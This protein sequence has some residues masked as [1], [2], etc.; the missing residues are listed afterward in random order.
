MNIVDDDSTIDQPLLHPPDHTLLL[1]AVQGNAAAIVAALGAKARL[2]PI[3]SVSVLA[4][5]A[6]LKAVD[7]RTRQTAA[8]VLAFL[9]PLSHTELPASYAATLDTIDAALAEAHHPMEV[10]HG[11]LSVRDA[12]AHERVKGFQIGV[13]VAI[14]LLGDALESTAGVTSAASVFGKRRPIDVARACVRGC[15]SGAMAGSLGSMGANVGA[16]VGGIGGSAQAAIE[17]T[18]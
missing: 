4:V 3:P 15:V 17:A 18:L 2:R 10:L 14:D 12:H 13:S 8:Q 6:A 5:V 11:L 9:A 1:R 7:D 16:I